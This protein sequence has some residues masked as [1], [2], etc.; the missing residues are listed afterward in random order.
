MCLPAS[1]NK[2]YDDK[3]QTKT[4]HLAESVPF[5]SIESSANAFAKI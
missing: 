2:K 5:S 3:S 4:K 1:R